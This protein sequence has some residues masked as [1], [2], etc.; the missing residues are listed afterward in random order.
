M[1][2]PSLVAVADS[3]GDA[4]LDATMVGDLDG[5]IATIR[6]GDWIDTL[7]AGATT[8]VDVASTAIDPCGALLANGLGWA[9]EY[10]QPLR[11]M[12]DMLTGAPGRVAAHAAT[13]Q[14]IAADLDGTAADLKRSLHGDL[15]DWQGAAAGAYA[16][17]MSHNVAALSTL[18]G[19]AA[20]M[21]AATEAAGN[22]VAFTRDLVRG[23]IAD[24]V[25]RLAVWAAEALA[26]V[27]IPVVATQIVAAVATWAARI[28]GYTT[29]LTT[30]LTNLS[31]LIDG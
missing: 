25:S 5:L 8:G 28:V 19:T 23:L 10:F 1:T 20:A 22:L 9:M 16:A 4:A 3:G 14:H 27:T 11:H 18:S 15:P 6:G 21:S 29:A 17:M 30:S 2:S 7:L 24:L 26:V 31:H 13:W 12:L